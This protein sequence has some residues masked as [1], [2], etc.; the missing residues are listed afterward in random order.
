M[1]CE[2]LDAMRLVLAGNAVAAD[3]AHG[4][5]GNTVAS[6][7]PPTPMSAATLPGQDAAQFTPATAATPDNPTPSTGVPPF[8]D[9][10]P[11]H[12]LAGR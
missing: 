2:M 6:P 3:S 11:K 12:C 5:K 7:S 8:T 9:A 1:H 10:H 4:S